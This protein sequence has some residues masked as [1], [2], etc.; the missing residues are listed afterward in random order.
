LGQILVRTLGL[1]VLG[2]FMVNAESSGDDRVMGMGIAPWAL[3]MYAAVLL[4]WCVYPS[5][6]GARRWVYIGLRVV[7]LSILV[8]LYAL[9]R[10]EDG[11]RM[12]PRWWGILGLIGWAY[13]I[14]C[15]LYLGL[16]KQLPA[17]VGCLGLLIAFYVGVRSGNLELPS[18]LAFLHGQA[19]NASHGA[20]VVAGIIVSLL[21]FESSPAR[22]VRQ[23]IAWLVV[24]AA[25]LLAAGFLLRPL[26]GISK[27]HAT[28]TWSLYCSAI[29]VLVYTLLYWIVDVTH[30]TRWTRL[31]KPAGSNPLLTYIL[32]SIVY[33]AISWLN[34]TILPSRFGAGPLG[35]VRAGIFTL[36]ILGLAALLTRWKI[37]LHL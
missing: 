14:S 22:S 21:F 29:G 35:I 20:L 30:V 5:T 19:G 3:L 32:P 36:L 15:A 8:L 28:P 7:G 37:R 11:S 26:H 24:F 17:M 16:R 23:R 4:V 12:G 9:Y 2:A 25:S 10:N 33:Y 27:V 1:L 13:A 6:A 34:V 31:L 18:S